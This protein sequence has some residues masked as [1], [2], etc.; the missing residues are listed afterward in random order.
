M[1]YVG[2]I[3]CTYGMLQLHSRD[4]TTYARILLSRNGTKSGWYMISACDVMPGVRFSCVWNGIPSRWQPAIETHDVQIRWNAQRLSNI[5]LITVQ[6]FISL[7]LN[8]KIF[9]QEQWVEFF[10]AYPLYDRATIYIYFVFKTYFYKCLNMQL[11]NNLF[12]LV[13]FCIRLYC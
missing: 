6:N 8:R 5:S 2:T 13:L 4:G 9:L 12:T 11:P 7:S 10:F 1:A 3:Q